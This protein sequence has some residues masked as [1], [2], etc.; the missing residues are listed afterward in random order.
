MLPP[1]RV[2]R[3]ADPA[4][5]VKARL[6]MQGTLTGGAVYSSTLDA[7]RRVRL[8]NTAFRHISAE[9]KASIALR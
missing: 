1:T 4:D 3:P 7:F 5:T 6:Q 8:I 9:L 2:C